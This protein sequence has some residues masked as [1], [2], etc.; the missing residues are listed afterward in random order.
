MEKLSIF[1]EKIE[2]ENP[3]KIFNENENFIQT[4]FFFSLVNK[5]L[6]FRLKKKIDSDYEKI[7]KGVKG[8]FKFDENK[9][10]EKNE[11]L[12]LYMYMMNRGKFYYHFHYEILKFKIILKNIEKK[13][14]ENKRTKSADDNDN[15]FIKKEISLIKDKIYDFDE[16]GINK[17]HIRKNYNIES[18]DNYE[19]DNIAEVDNNNDYAMSYYNYKEICNLNKLYK[20]WKHNLIMKNGLIYNEYFP[21]NSF[22]MTNMNFNR[23]YKRYNNKESK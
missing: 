5:D 18:S 7:L 22:T 10:Q 21:F 3:K 2:K 6:S 17:I 19:N 9:T 20:T 4:N 23:F 11:L 1:I 15:D 16:I 12:L 8:L 14:K 13:I